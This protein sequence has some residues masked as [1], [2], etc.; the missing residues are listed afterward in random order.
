[1]YNLFSGTVFQQTHLTPVQVV[2][3]IRGICKGE[4]S[5]ERVEELQL[6]CGTVLT[7]RH[8]IKLNTE[9]AQPTTLFPDRHTETDEMSQNSGEKRRGTF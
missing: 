8:E 1:M 7:L 9:H 6:N 3:L 5:E 2:L 4:N